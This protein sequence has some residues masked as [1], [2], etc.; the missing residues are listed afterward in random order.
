MKVL[1]NRKCSECQVPE[2]DDLSKLSIGWTAA[3]DINI[4]MP[5]ISKF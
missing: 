3:K 2:E 4:I 5:G 1:T